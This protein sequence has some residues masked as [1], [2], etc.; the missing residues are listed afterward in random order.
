MIGSDVRFDLSDTLDAGFSASL[1]H[2]LDARAINYSLGPN[3]GITPFTNGW[4][5]VGYNLVGFHDRDFDEARYTRSGPYVTMRL[6]FDQ[7]S[8]QDLRKSVR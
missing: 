1:R 3:I 5:S 2:D 8:L 4:L 6:K 7:L